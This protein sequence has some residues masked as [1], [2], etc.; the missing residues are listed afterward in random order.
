M[1]V[2]GM[3]FIPERLLMMMM[4]LTPPYC[5]IAAAIG[6]TLLLGLLL[7]LNATECRQSH[8]GGCREDGPQK[9]ECRECM[10]GGGAQGPAH[11][12]TYHMIVSSLKMPACPS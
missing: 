12:T 2:G 4:M 5:E 8:L 7:L 9:G 6:S 11:A 3:G 1:T 10:M